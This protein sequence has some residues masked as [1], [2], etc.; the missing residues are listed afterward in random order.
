MRSARRAVP[1]ALV[2]LL[3]SAPA[4]AGDKAI[5]WCESLDT[6]FARAGDTGLPVAVCVTAPQKQAGGSVTGGASTMLTEG[7]YKE[8]SV[9]RRSPRFVWVL[10]DELPDAARARL[11]T[12][13]G[14][15]LIVTPQH[16][17]VHPD[18]KQVLLRKEYWP[19]GKGEAGV[20]AF[21]KLLD[22]AWTRFRL[23]PQGEKA[24]DPAAPKK[25]P[26]GD[27]GKKKKDEV[28]DEAEARKDWVV[29][30]LGRIRTGNNETRRATLKGLIKHD[31][32]GDCITPLIDL[33]S[34]PSL[35]K[36]SRIDVV[37][38]L[39]IPGLG[40]AVL[41]LAAL[42]QHD[43]NRVRGNAAV[44]LEYIG[45][46]EAVPALKKQ[47]GAERSA[48]VAGHICRALGRCGAGKSDVRSALLKRWDKAETDTQRIGPAAG[49]AYFAGDKSLA[50]K[51]EKRLAKAVVPKAITGLTSLRKEPKLLAWCLAHIGDKRS[52]KF[53]RSK[54]IDRLKR[55]SFNTGVGFYEEVV[56][57]IEGDEEAAK[58]VDQ[59]MRGVSFGGPGSS[60]TSI[61]S[62]VGVFKMDAMRKGRDMSQ[63]IP[64]GDWKTPTFE[65]PDPTNR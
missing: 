29:A 49:M 50:R 44:S 48:S 35:E 58:A 30:M 64:K 11:K 2:L 43:D 41:P 57:M 19:Y 37:R 20:R 6:A 21:E 5:R 56:L 52:A 55:E 13:T 63:F 31:R 7:I 3:L 33:L 53:M 59:S 32:N 39:G 18:G 34:D 16:V 61:S 25:E 17:F 27:K 24:A 42:L 15:E 60:I 40:D 10:V 51:I 45:L 22:D 8:A 46:P 36:N 65:L 38:A 23:T 62:S 12:L 1:W 28:P 47:L 14:S 54:V 26:E 4:Q 9:V